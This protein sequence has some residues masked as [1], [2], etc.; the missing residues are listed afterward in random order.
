MDVVVRG[1]CIYFFLLIV[2]RLSGR[3]TLGESTTFDFVLMLI[4]AETTQQA[5][6]GDDYSI[7]TAIILITTLTGADILLSLVKCRWPRAERIIDGLPLVVVDEGRPL[8]D[9]MRRSR[10]DEE[11]ILAAARKIQGLERMDQIKYAVLEPNGG[12]SII[13]KRDA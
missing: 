5:L 11:D 6:L 9:R 8:P 12:I 1:L 13:P 2:M 7:T 3:R 4:I 10:I